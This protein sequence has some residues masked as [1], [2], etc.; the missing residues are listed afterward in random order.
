MSETAK[1]LPTKPKG[2]RKR[3]WALTYATIADW[4]G[5]APRSVIQYASRGDFRPNNIESVLAWAN[6]RR[7]RRGLPPIGEACDKVQPDETTTVIMPPPPIAS[8][9]NPLTGEFSS[10]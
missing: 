5:L 7:R 9:Y 3:L 4:T 8:T 6:E 1:Y 2:A 10:D